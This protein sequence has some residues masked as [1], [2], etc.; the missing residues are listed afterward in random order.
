MESL[1][2]SWASIVSRKT[3]PVLL[4]SLLTL[5][6]LSLGMMQAKEFEDETVIWTPEVSDVK[7][8]VLFGAFEIPIN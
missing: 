8:A 7:A 2:S 6:L 1:F 3:L 5:L 4:I